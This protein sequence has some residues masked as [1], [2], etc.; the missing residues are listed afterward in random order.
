MLFGAKNQ[1][2]RLFFFFQI[3]DSPEND[4]F[5]RV[6]FLCLCGAFFAVSYG[7]GII[8]ESTTVSIDHVLFVDNAFFFITQ[9]CKTG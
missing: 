2:V 6:L 1:L 4:D 9:R 5:R 7:N 3:S 8:I